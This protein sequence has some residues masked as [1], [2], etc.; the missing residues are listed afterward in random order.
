MYV[1]NLHGLFLSPAIYC[2]PLPAGP[3]SNQDPSVPWGGIVRQVEQGS[4]HTGTCLGLNSRDFE[5][6]KSCTQVGVR[7]HSD[8]VPTNGPSGSQRNMEMDFLIRYLDYLSWGNNAN[9]FCSNRGPAPND[10]I[11]LNITTSNEIW[12]YWSPSGTLNT[13]SDSKSL[14]YNKNEDTSRFIIGFNGVAPIKSNTYM[15]QIHTLI[16]WYKY[17]GGNIILTELAK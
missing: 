8:Q 15:P 1:E 2:P 10:T 13:E 3:A 17:D 5:T 11:W 7:V 12:G 4:L 6:P 14:F 9:T 16:A